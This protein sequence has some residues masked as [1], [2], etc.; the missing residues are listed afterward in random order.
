MKHGLQ[1]AF[2]VKKAELPQL[3]GS[4]GVVAFRLNQCPEEGEEV[5]LN[6]SVDKGDKDIALVSA[7]RIV[8]HC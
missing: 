3:S 7:D 8:F 5:V 2:G 1:A 4:A 6:L